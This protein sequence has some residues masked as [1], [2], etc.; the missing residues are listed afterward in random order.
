MPKASYKLRLVKYD[1]KYVLKQLK[2]GDTVETT[3]TYT[4]AVNYKGINIKL[5][6]SGNAEDI[7]E[8]FSNYNFDINK[9]TFVQI[10][11]NS[12]ITQKVLEEFADNGTDDEEEEDDLSDYEE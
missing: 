7:R 12:K 5:L 8:N 6:L 4:L 2:G 10:D 3:E 1:P 9:K 11:L